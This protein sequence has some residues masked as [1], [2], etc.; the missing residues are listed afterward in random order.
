MTVGTPSSASPRIKSGGRH[1]L[2]QKSGRTR[3]AAALELHAQAAR[4]G[5]LLEALAELA[6]V[7]HEDLGVGRKLHAEA[8]AHERG[9][10]AE[11]DAVA[12]N[13][14]AGTPTSKALSDWEASP[15]SWVQPRRSSGVS[16]PLAVAMREV[17]RTPNVVWKEFE[18]VEFTVNAPKPPVSL[19]PSTCAF[20]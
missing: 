10:A 19:K 8:R 9:V 16:V 20:T 18:S 15:N 14:L 2:P 6:V 5:V 7:I 3:G 17:R 4:D 12:E 11:G 1:L 13:E